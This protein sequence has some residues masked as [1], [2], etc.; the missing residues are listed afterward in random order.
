MTIT[1]GST[2]VKW[3]N[4]IEYINGE[5]WG[6]IWQTECIARVDPNDGSVIGWILMDG[7]GAFLH[8]ALHICLLALAPCL[9]LFA[10]AQSSV[11][12]F[13]RS[14]AHYSLTKRARKAATARMDV[15]NGIAFDA[16]SN[17]LWVTGKKWPM[18][19]EIEVEE[20]PTHADYKNRLTDARRRCIK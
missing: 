20:L 15:L 12:D 3:L 8:P 19:Y 1:D 2:A 7:C 14:L 5:V 10:G 9:Y 13:L 18:L 16:P 6:M 17:R 11:S 4:E